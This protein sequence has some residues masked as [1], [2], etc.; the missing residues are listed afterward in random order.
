MEHATNSVAHVQTLRDLFAEQFA[1]GIGK[2][3]A[4][5]DSGSLHLSVSVRCGLF[6]IHSLVA[7]HNRRTVVANA[8]STIA[9]GIMEESPELS[10]RPGAQSLAT[11]IARA[12]SGH[13]GCGDYYRDY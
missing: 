11:V 7:N 4:D 10:R 1:R 8:G 3:M 2:R 5:C 12:A 13:L 9:C 6:E